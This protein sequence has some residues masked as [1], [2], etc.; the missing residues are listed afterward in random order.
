MGSLA[1]PTLRRSV[2]PTPTTK[3]SR[4]AAL[5]AEDAD[6]KVEAPLGMPEGLFDELSLEG[7]LDEDLGEFDGYCDFF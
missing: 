1:V 3:R 4:R 7:F 6:E 2:T 5:A